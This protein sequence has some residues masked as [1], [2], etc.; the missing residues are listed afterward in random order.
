MNRYDEYGPEGDDFFS[1]SRRLTRSAAIFG[2]GRMLSFLVM[3]ALGLMSFV[4][5]H[6][7]WTPLQNVGRNI[8]IGRGDAYF[9]KPNRT[10]NFAN[11]VGNM[12]SNPLG[13][14]QRYP[15][16]PASSVGYT[17]PTSFVAAGQNLQQNFQQA[18]QPATYA[19]PAQQLT[20]PQVVSKHGGM[21]E[22]AR[23]VQ[24]RTIG[25]RLASS[26]QNL[27]PGAMRF[28]LLKDNVSPQAYTIADGSVLI[29]SALYSGLRSEGDLAAILSQRITEYIYRGYDVR[30]N[31][32]VAQFRTQMLSAAGFDPR[33]IMDYESA[34]SASQ[35]ASGGVIRR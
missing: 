27:Q 25:N 26:V 5:K 31:T 2:R 15:T 22:D 9:P 10:A 28:Y 16:Q 33:V 13:Q 32:Q 1:R 18:W 23:T 8:N 7:S 4:S 34:R 12:A 19:Q 21:V 14:A 6:T 29:T 17:Q 3:A 11:A 35:I 20:G 24:V 30:N